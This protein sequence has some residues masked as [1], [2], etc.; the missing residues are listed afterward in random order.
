[1]IQIDTKQKIE[2]IR[3]R[4]ED[5]AR[6]LTK[7]SDMDLK[8][9]SGFLTLEL[10]F[11]SFL[12]TQNICSWIIKIT[13]IFFQLTLCFV[14]GWVLYYNFKRRKEVVK[15]IKNCNEFLGFNESKAYLE[16]GKIDLDTK[17]RSWFPIY[18]I[19]ILASFLAVAILIIAS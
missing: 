11:G 7:L 2:L 17:P 15:T 8:I 12:L 4:H 9:F 3:Y 19:G 6:L 5:Q 1:M 13:M 16:N 18:S 14:C 10:V